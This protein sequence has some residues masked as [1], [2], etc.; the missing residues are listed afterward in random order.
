MTPAAILEELRVEL[1]LPTDNM[2]ALSKARQLAAREGF[3]ET[4]QS[5]VATAASEL[6]TNILRYGGG[7]EIILRRIQDGARH[8]VEIR[9]E[10]HGPGIADLESA[11]RDNFSTGKS[12]GLGLPGVKR[13]M[14]EFSIDTRV[15]EG[16]LCVARM[17]RR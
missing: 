8:G 6:A 3:G 9:A 14:D 17:W 4:A 10:D 7:G 1:A 13:I 16:T 2:L 5:L 12:L 15:G 11:M